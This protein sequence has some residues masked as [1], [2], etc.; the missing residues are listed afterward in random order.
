MGCCGKN[1]TSAPKASPRYPS[2]Q[3]IGTSGLTVQGPVSLRQYRFAAPGATVAVDGR[4]APSL[5]LV[6]LLRRVS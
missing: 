5:E 2:F 4:D 1:T 3:Y 6:P